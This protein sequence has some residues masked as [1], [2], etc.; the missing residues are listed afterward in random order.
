[1]AWDIFLSYPSAELPQARALQ[2]L[3]A[4]NH[5]LQAFLSRTD[6]VPGD[7]WEP[8]LKRALSETS[9]IAVL[10]TTATPD[11]YYQR[12]EVEFAIDLTRGAPRHSGSCPCCSMVR[13]A[14]SSTSACVR[15]T[16]SR[17]RTQPG[18]PGSPSS[19]RPLFPPC[20]TGGPTRRSPARANSPTSCGSG[21]VRRT[22]TGFRRCPRSFGQVRG[23]WE[24]HRGARGRP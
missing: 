22:P 18:W 3:L 11:A 6:L 13:P 8:Q 24:R 9:V 7:L 16:R 12:A 5:H 1:M 10:V 2:E 23:R 15:S 21:S 19:S 14:H 20:R 17:R 4:Q